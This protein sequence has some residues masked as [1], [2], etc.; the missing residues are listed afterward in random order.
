MEEQ[1]AASIMEARKAVE[2]TADLFYQQKNPDGYTELN[3]TITKLMAVVDE[4][5]HRQTIDNESLIIVDQTLNSALA[6]AMEAIERKDTILLADIL[7]FDIDKKLKES[8][9]CI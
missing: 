7:A 8:L 5:M 6:K 4:L 3:L 1:L 2:H 9:E